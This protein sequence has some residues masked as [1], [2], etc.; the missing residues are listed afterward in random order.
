MRWRLW[1]C[2]AVSGSAVVC[3]AFG[4]AIACHGETIPHRTFAQHTNTCGHKKNYNTK[5]RSFGCGG[6]VRH[7]K[8]VAFCVVVLLRLV[9]AWDLVGC[10]VRLR[11]FGG[12]RRHVTIVAQY[13]RP[14]YRLQVQPDGKI[15]HAKQ[16]AQL[17]SCT[18]LA[19]YSLH[20]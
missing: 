1:V 9:A 5:R 2:V 12:L 15:K 17:Q 7:A 13:S 18:T 4:L 14:G 16:M 6:R 19:L 20:R 8:L 10:C 11:H 3:F